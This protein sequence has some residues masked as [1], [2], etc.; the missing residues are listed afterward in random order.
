MTWY[1]VQTAPGAFRQTKTRAIEIGP[2]GGS[3]VHTFRRMETE[4][5]ADLS[6]AGIGFYIPFEQ[7]QIVH[8]RTKK[9]LDRRFPLL[10]GYAFVED[11]TDWPALEALPTVAA[12][13]GD[14]E[15]RPERVL[16]AE[17][18]KIKD[19]EAMAADA[20]QREKERIAEAR[21]KLTRKRA[22]R[23]FPAGSTVE[24]DHETLGVRLGSVVGVTGRK[25]VKVMAEFLGGLVPIEVPVD[26]ARM[27]A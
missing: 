3:K 2:R 8:H 10:P 20:Y 4:I 18:G 7:R 16:N 26:A 14:M 11:V 21:K 13:L 17:I 5:E 1:A 6:R 23:M 27:V 12:I 24:V 25:T 15:G 9:L 22:A 19:A